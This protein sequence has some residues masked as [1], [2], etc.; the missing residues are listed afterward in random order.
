MDSNINLDIGNRIKQRRLQLNMSQANL[1]EKLGLRNRST[2]TRYE[3]GE[4][5]F[6][7][8]QIRALAEALN[9][10]PSYLMGW[11]EPPNVVPVDLGQ[12]TRI[13]VYGRIPAGI[14]IGAIEDIEGYIDIPLE[15]TKSH[16]YFA[17]HVKGDSMFPKYQEDD[18]VVIRV[19]QDCESGQDCV[20][21]VNGYDATLKRVIKKA[22]CIILQPLNPAYEPRVY[23]YDEESES[24]TIA[25]V[26]VE[27]RRKVL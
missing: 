3:Q 7:Q 19:Q 8:S 16:E 18:Y 11:D 21:Y 22:D 25:G 24:V 12:P 26:V 23:Y 17:L 13:P 2:I 10:T 5:T 6:K 1:A 14:P 15:W 9:T 4:K 27:I 20:V